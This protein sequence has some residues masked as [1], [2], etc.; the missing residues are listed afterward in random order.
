MLAISYCRV[1]GA[2]SDSVESARGRMSARPKG[3]FDTF[4]CE[5]EPYLF[6]SVGDMNCGGPEAEPPGVVGV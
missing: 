6:G 3:V 1:P 5:D 4:R 2:P